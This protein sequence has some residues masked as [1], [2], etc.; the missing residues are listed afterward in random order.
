MSD[1][2]CLALYNKGEAVQKKL[3]THLLALENRYLIKYFR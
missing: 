1:L 3:D 2:I